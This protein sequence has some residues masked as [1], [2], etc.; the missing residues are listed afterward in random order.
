MILTSFNQLSWQCRRGMLELDEILLKFLNNHYANLS[1]DLKLKFNQLLESS[2]ADLFDWLL[3]KSLPSNIEFI[4]LI[5]I[6]RKNLLGS[7]I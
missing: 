2:D 6:I 1:L 5:S 4:D 3:N 7:N